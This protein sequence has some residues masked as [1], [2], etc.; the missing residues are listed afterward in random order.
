M[1][2]FAVISFD[3]TNGTY[4]DYKNAYAE[5]GNLG[6]NKVLKSDDGSAVP[7]PSTTCAGEFSGRSA[8]SLRDTLR[9]KVQAAF[10]SRSLKAEIFITVGADWA[11]GYR[12]T[13]R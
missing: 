5:L 10:Q 13:D 7:L 11:F 2:Y 3:I 9:D 12:T 4:D 6:F 8:R 1:P